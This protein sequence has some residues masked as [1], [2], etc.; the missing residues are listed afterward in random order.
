M[1]VAAVAVIVVT[2]YSAAVLE[3]MKVDGTCTAISY[4]KADT[5]EAFA[6][7]ST[8]TFGNSTSYTLVVTSVSTAPVET[9]NITSYTTNS[10]PNGTSVS[11]FT[12]TST[13]YGDIPSAG[14]T[15]TACTYP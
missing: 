6:T 15:V 13:D 14:W 11:A 7:N 12:S 5:E 4:F 9:V 8:V 1:A 3:G 2:A 10:Y